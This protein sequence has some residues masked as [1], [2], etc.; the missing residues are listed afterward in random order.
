MPNI[1]H[2]FCP[3]RLLSI[4][5]PIGYGKCNSAPGGFL[6]EKASA[7]LLKRIKQKHYSKYYSYA[8]KTLQ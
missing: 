5:I 1:D 4:Q 3:Y 2:I 8:C 6:K 7:S